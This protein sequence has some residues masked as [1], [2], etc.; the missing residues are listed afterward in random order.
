MNMFED[1]FYRMSKEELINLNNKIN[2]I[3]NELGCLG[4]DGN[5]LGDIDEERCGLIGYIEEN[6]DLNDNEKELLGL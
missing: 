1:N 3:I 4:L 6:Y 2:E 5:Y